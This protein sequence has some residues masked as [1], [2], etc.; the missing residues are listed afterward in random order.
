VEEAHTVRLVGPD[1]RIRARFILIAVGAHPVLEPRIP[2]GG[3]PCC[4]RRT[5]PGHL[6]AH[7]A[8]DWL[9][10]RRCICGRHPR[11]PRCGRGGP[12]RSHLRRAGCPSETAPR[13]PARSRA[14]SRGGHRQLHSDVYA[15][16]VCPGVRVPRLGRPLWQ[17]YELVGKRCGCFS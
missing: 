9:A 3:S 4:D 11:P 16:L 6:G 1:T 10:P 8:L 17:I 5:G 2:G 14:H 13:V 15:A 7:A 12:P